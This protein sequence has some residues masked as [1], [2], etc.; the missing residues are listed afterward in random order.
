MFGG[1]PIPDNPAAWCA[2]RQAEANK[3]P[4]EL[5]VDELFVSVALFYK[6]QARG[7]FS[8]QLDSKMRQSE[9]MMRP[10]APRAGPAAVNPPWLT[11]LR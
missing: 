7:R 3:S 8:L 5:F 11:R 4:D 6:Q 1:W 10:V 9:G 2:E